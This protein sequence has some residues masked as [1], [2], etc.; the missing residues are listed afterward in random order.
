[1]LSTGVSLAITLVVFGFIL[2]SQLQVRVAR[3]SLTLPAV[4]GLVG[5]VQF[6]QGAGREPLSDAGIA[7]LGASFLILAIGLGA[8]RAY[9]VRLWRDGG[10]VL[11]QGTW[12]TASLWIVGAALHAVVDAQAHSA[13]ATY[14]LYLGLTLAAQRIVVGA[15]A[16]RLEASA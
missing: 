1:M 6:G 14:L 12:V 5:A 8:V 4:L 10:K 13:A 9:T 16:R 7:L 15:R 3:T 11:R 2:R